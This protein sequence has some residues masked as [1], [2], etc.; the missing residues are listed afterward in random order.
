MKRFRRTQRQ[1]AGRN[2]LALCLLGTVLLLLSSSVLTLFPGQA[3][4]YEE[5]YAG[6]GETTVITHLST[7]YGTFY[8]SANENALLVTPFHRGLRTPPH[9]NG[10]A[11]VGWYGWSEASACDLTEQ[12]GSF[13]AH[14]FTAQREGTEGWSLTQIYGR[15]DMEGANSVTGWNRDEPGLSPKTQSLI[16]GKDRH[17]YFWFLTEGTAE[18]P[19][20]LYTDFTILDRNG[21]PL[22]QY[23]LSPLRPF[24][25]L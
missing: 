14:C 22:G 8:L 9:P 4:R 20:P 5:R 10:S 23:H 19:G 16:R 11:R 18:A 1:K 25:Y 7:G 24:L 3:I 2:G 15:V 6:T 13:C 21:K 12:K 17:A